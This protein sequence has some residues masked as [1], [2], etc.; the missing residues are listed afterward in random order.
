MVLA[1]CLQIREWGA[2][3]LNINHSCVVM[4]HC[5]T[6]YSWQGGLPWSI[7]VL[8]MRDDLH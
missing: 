2:G 7:V 6:F 3:V 1:G 4:N 8:Q 5:E